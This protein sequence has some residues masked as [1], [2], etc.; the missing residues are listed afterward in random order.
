MAMSDRL[1]DPTSAIASCEMY[2]GGSNLGY[3]EDTHPLNE[4]RPSASIP[5]KRFDCVCVEYTNANV[6][7]LARTSF[8][9]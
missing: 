1:H 2:L 6:C 5:E 4:A 7:I 3:Q 8:S 9:K